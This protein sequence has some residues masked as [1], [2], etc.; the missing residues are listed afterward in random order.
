MSSFTPTS[1]STKLPGTHHA[2]A[3]VGLLSTQSSIQKLA[4]VAVISP[5]T[6]VEV[7]TLRKLPSVDFI[8]VVA[9]G[10]PYADSEGCP[11][12][13]DR[14][15]LS[16][17]K[18]ALDSSPTRVPRSSPSTSPFAFSASPVVDPR[19]SPSLSTYPETPVRS[20]SPFVPSFQPIPLNASVQRALHAKKTPVTVDPRIGTVDVVNPS[21][22]GCCFFACFRGLFKKKARVAPIIVIPEIKDPRTDE[23][24]LHEL[25]AKNDNLIAYRGIKEPHLYKLFID[26]RRWEGNPGNP[27][28]I[29]KTRATFDVREPGYLYAM[30]TAFVHLMSFPKGHFLT[31][32]HLDHT[33]IEYLHSLCVDGVASMKDGV[34]EA[35]RKHYRAAG[36]HSVEA[37]HL[38]ASESAED[39]VTPGVTVTHEGALEL[40]AKMV[41]PLYEYRIHGDTHNKFHAIEDALTSTC[42]RE[43]INYKRYVEACAATEATGIDPSTIEKVPLP[44]KIVLQR[45]RTGA[46]IT[47]LVNQII[48]VFIISPKENKQQKLKA[49]ARVIQDLDQIHP[50]YDG[51]I[52]VFA[53]LLLNRL[54]YDLDL[55][56]TC[57][58]DPNCF[59]CLSIDQLVSA[60]EKGQ[61]HFA[62]LK[63][64]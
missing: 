30:K 62:S 45:V 61:T 20:D 25:I 15:A 53:I 21:D 18:G 57:L 56:P 11:F 35:L 50:F 28:P 43:F 19:Y 64:K 17:I 24:D 12:E 23:K 1:G 48:N 16:S 59:D 37:F 49:V 41:N 60:I 51:N 44:S 58:E 63:E 39:G 13:I 4:P 22:V 34:P 10:R 31:R 26:Q 33:F 27:D 46:S 40:C 54:L 29:Y 36:D 42:R 52:R 9:G 6:A 3:G 55:A 8:H 47:P 7:V 14:L 32:E 2:H 38:K 5:G